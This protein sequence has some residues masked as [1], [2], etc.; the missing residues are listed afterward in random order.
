VRQAEASGFRDLALPAELV[1]SL[2]L[3]AA[4][5]A[6]HEAW[7]WSLNDDSGAKAEIVPLPVL[8]E[9]AAR[10][11]VKLVS[12]GGATRQHAG[13]IHTYGYLL[14]NLRTPFGYKRARWLS[15]VLDRGLGLPA[16][17]LGPQPRGDTTLLSRVTF[18]LMRVATHRDH[19]DW[20]NW[21]KRLAPRATP[22]LQAL[23][24]RGVQRRTE[25]LRLSSGEVVQLVTDLVPLEQDP[26]RGRLLV[27]S[28]RRG[29]RVQLITG[30][31]VDAR[32]QEKPAQRVR[33]RYNAWLE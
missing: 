33:P 28:V 22:E 6:L 18:L 4:D 20:Q 15:G 16:G 1:R 30:F 23:A 29:G 14:S 31:P 9:L 7:G 8:R 12:E 10:F 26:D 21:Q 25:E 2:E 11:G 27:Y 5:P 24:L 19:G 13:L 17:T 32:F 3:D